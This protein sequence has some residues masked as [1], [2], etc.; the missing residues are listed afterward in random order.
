[1]QN[2]KLPA[3]AASICNHTF[4]RLQIGPISSNLSNEHKLVVPNVTHT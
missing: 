2:P 4:S 3:Y 1:M